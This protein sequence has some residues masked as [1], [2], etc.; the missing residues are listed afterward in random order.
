[1][2]MYDEAHALARAVRS[3][4][5]M[6]KL[7]A[8]KERVDADPATKKMVD[9]FLAKQMQ[10]EYSQMLGKEL[11]EEAQ[12]EF[13]DLAVLIANNSAAQEYLQAFARWQQVASDLQKIV[14]EAMSEGMPD[15]ADMLPEEP[16][17]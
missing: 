17:A 9:E 12:R 3:S 1:M 15:F 8:A 14:G 10:R 5:E 16:E 4:D 13:Q 7:T 2:N 11:D 6:K